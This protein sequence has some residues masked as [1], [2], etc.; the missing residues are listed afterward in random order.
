MGESKR[1]CID[2]D[3]TLCIRDETIALRA[4]EV[5]KK[6]EDSGHEIY[7]NQTL[8]ETKRILRLS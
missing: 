7:W 1:I 8:E 3:D 6:L 5:L 2:F 4:K